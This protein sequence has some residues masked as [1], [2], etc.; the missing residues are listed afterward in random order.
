MVLKRFYVDWVEW[1]SLNS[2]LLNLFVLDNPSQAVPADRGGLPE[3]GSLS[4]VY[5]VRAVQASVVTYRYGE[6]D[7]FNERFLWSTS[8]REGAYWPTIDALK[9]AYPWDHQGLLFAEPLEGLVEIMADQ[10]AERFYYDWR[11][12][13]ICHVQLIR[14][15]LEPQVTWL[16]YDQRDLVVARYN[17]TH[18]LGT[19]YAYDPFG[20]VVQ[21]YDL[22]PLSERMRLNVAY[23][24]QD[25]AA[26]HLGDTVVAVL[27]P[28]VDEQSNVALEEQSR[29]LGS[30]DYT[31]TGHVREVV[32]GGDGSAA[33]TNRYTYDMRNWLMSQQVQIDGV[34]TYS[35]DLDYFGLGGLMDGDGAAQTLKMFDG[36]IAALSENYHLE[37]GEHGL[38][39][40]H[41]YGYD[42]NYQLTRSVQR[43]DAVL[44][45]RYG[46]D[47]NGN[48]IREHRIDT[49]N[50]LRPERFNVYLN[51][52][53]TPGTNQLATVRKDEGYANNTPRYRR[54]D[55]RYD[56]MGNVVGIQRFKDGD[57]A[58]EVD[59]SFTYGDARYRH[60]PTRLAQTSY[61]NEA[62]SGYATETRDYRYN[63]DGTRIYRSVQK[64]GD[65]P[66]ITYFVPN[67]LENAA[68]LDAWG[69]ARRAYVFN[70]GERIAYKSKANTGLYIKDHLGSTKLVIALNRDM[71]T[72]ESEVTPPQAPTPPAVVPET[73][74]SLAFDGNLNAVGQ[75]TESSFIGDANYMSRFDDRALWLDRNESLQINDPAVAQ[76]TEQFTI[77]LWAYDNDE[78]DGEWDHGTMVTV[79]GGASIR[80]NPIH[81]YFDGNK[82]P[83]LRLG[84]GA[85]GWQFFSQ[86][87]RM[88][89][90][91]WVHLAVTFDGQ[92]V[93]CYQ[94]GE[95]LG[96]PQAVDLPALFPAEDLHLGNW[97][98][99]EDYA[100]EGGL[101]EVVIAAGA[102]DQ[103]AI[104][105]HFLRT[106]PGAPPQSEAGQARNLP[107]D[108]ATRDRVRALLILTRADADAFG[109]TLNESYGALAG[110][111]TE[112]HQFTGQEVEKGLGLI[113]MNGRWYLPEVGRFLQA[114]PLRQ[115]WNVYIYVGNN[116]VNRVDP[117]GL[118]DDDVPDGS[119]PSIFENM[120]VTSYEMLHEGGMFIFGGVNA[121]FSNLL[122][123]AGRSDE[124][125]W[126]FRAGQTAGDAFAT[127]AGGVMAFGGV[128]ILAGGGVMVVAGAPVLITGGVL[129]GGA[130]LV[131]GGVVAITSFHRGINEAPEWRTHSRS[132][133]NDNSS[134]SPGG[135]PE[136]APNAKVLF[137]HGYPLEGEK[138][139]TIKFTKE[140]YQNL[141]D[142]KGLIRRFVHGDLSAEKILKSRFFLHKLN[143]EK[144][145]K[146]WWSISIKME[147]NSS[148]E[149]LRLIFKLD[150]K[151]LHVKITDYH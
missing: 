115:Y 138:N 68:E 151:G 134:A 126:T 27:G 57:G 21:S 91:T 44:T 89:V 121:F 5:R 137:K 132:K 77:M 16:R 72:D 10:S 85:D 130:L 59:Q 51:H 35:V 64:G 71:P 75:V 97:P 69:R 30:W 1:A 46:Y 145:Y 106:S 110:G 9:A 141:W 103:G 119:E 100:W 101:D 54:L 80:Y 47:R 143:V 66:E 83:V 60:Q 19:G 7:L 43:R 24:H 28:L 136:P 114:D 12:R 124:Q 62:E 33:I 20:R 8:Y 108:Q 2:P 78:D 48:R 93:R 34:D 135:N 3:D 82:L 73:V 139:P 131:Y 17:Q 38:V 113:Y 142:A 128:S 117:T 70:G 109:I 111:K 63:Q 148:K 25:A 112:P 40:Q 67:G 86:F 146:G 149:G 74:V 26:D 32:Y 11:G 107:A 22:A 4:A 92:F 120:T 50:P 102:K 95:L 31:I 104:R 79:G 61:G 144:S 15:V 116:P 147:N 122:M 18:H 42:G 13:M 37:G 56:E 133:G 6:Y 87:G 49:N 81:F 14:G 129:V 94:D 76:L 52:E 41:E 99:H 53:L 140:G 36:S 58:L 150:S 39:T 88:P 29:Q 118:E 98:G 65:R 123:G 45:H 96:E 55:F 90:K 127:T 125:D 23:R 105:D 84:G